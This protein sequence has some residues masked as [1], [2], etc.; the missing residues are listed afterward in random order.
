[1]YPTLNISLNIPENFVQQR[2][3]YFFFS[4][5]LVRDGK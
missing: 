4:K 1:M 2:E 3:S 5:T